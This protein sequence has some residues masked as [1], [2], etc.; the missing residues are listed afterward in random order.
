[1][2][3]PLTCISLHTGACHRCVQTP[4]RGISWQFVRKTEFWAKW[5]AE[6][7]QQHDV[8]VPFYPGEPCFY[9]SGLDGKIPQLFILFYCTWGL[10][11]FTNIS[12][13]ILVSWMCSRIWRS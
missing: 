4:E 7:V 11:R 6:L 1:M 10:T 9:R 5:R 13:F 3:N 8:I 12:V 2:G